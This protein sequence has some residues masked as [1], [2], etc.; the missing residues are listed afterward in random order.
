M[1]E[2]KHDIFV[3][4]AERRTTAVLNRIR[5]LSHCANAYAYE[6]SDEEVVKIFDAIDEELA[7]AKSKFEKERSREFR[8]S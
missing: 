7:S 6:Y 5:I 3:R 1:E 2:S 4:L 8:L